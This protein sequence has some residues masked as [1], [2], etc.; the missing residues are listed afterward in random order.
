MGMIIL[1]LFRTSVLPRLGVVQDVPCEV[2]LLQLEASIAVLVASVS[3]FRSLFASEGSRAARR[4]PKI[5][6]TAGSNLCK[7]KKRSPHSDS[8]LET[9]G[10]PPIPS[11]TMTG[12]R[13]FIRG[14]SKPTVPRS[15][16][17]EPFD[18]H[19]LDVDKT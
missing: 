12:L 17:D 10:L 15:E 1:G 11:A 4:K 19:L 7:R 14:N 5:G 16:S 6:W 8:D 9:N 13:S 3:A 2:F 18:D